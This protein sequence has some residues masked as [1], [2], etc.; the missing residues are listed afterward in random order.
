MS[1]E[2]K[3]EEKKKK[4]SIEKKK[5][6]KKIKPTK[7]I[8]VN[9]LKDYIRP[10]DPDTLEIEIIGA[11]SNEP[12]YLVNNF[13]KKGLKQYMSVKTAINAYNKIYNKKKGENG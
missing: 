11:L 5:S 3:I 7:K 2:K 13:I 4:S 9:K 12:Q 8:I 1:D 10:T 6:I